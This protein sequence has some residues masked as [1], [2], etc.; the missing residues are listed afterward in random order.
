[1]D[2]NTL[3]DSQFDGP[4]ALALNSQATLFIA[5][6]TNNAVRMV[7]SVG[8]VNNSTTV[9]SPVL[10]NLSQVVGVAVDAA[11]QPVCC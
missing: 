10:T 1:M 9:T 11:R 3:E 8:D 2:G 6:K 7:T 5:D 4:V